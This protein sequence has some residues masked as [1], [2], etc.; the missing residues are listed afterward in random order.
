M[1][2]NNSVIKRLWCSKIRSLMVL[3][4]ELKSNFLSCEPKRNAR[5]DARTYTFLRQIFFQV[6]SHNKLLA[7]PAYSY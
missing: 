5:V 6:G 7:K 1:D 4:C 3:S 2:P